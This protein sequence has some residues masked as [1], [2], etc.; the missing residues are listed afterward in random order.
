MSTTTYFIT[1]CSRGL[2]LEFTRQL[3]TDPNNRVIASARNPTSSPLLQ[4]LVKSQGSPARVVVVKLDVADPKSIEAAV[5]AT[6]K[7]EFAKNGIDVLI[8]NAGIASG[9]TKGVLAATREELEADLAV[10][11]LGTHS[12]VVG[13]LP[14]LRKGREKKIWSL[15]STMGSLSSP[16][17]NVP[18]GSM[19]SAS[20][21]GLNMYIRKL[22]GELVGE[23]FTLLLLCPGYVKT[24]A[25]GGVDG[26]AEIFPDESVS[27]SLKTLNSK[28]IKDTGTFW[29]YRG[30]AVPW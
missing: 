7:L 21:A 26:P 5:E 30:E 2:G 15:S 23:G 22:S 1:G 18:V 28:T 8:S 19:Y 12:L 20:K 16:M 27:K 10:N 29:N 4:E 25:N 3:L 9:S 17:G 13:L 11:L 24:D 6:A 14:L